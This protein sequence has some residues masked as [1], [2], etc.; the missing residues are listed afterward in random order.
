M[1]GKADGLYNLAHQSQIQIRSTIIGTA[2]Q[3]HIRSTK[4]ENDQQNL[5]ENL[6]GN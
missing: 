2:Y 5:I 1:H 6:I 4:V 3:S